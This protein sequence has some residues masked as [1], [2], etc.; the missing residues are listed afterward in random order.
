MIRLVADGRRPTACVNMTDKRESG[1]TTF[2]FHDKAIDM[3]SDPAQCSTKNTLARQ[4]YKSANH[5]AARQTMLSTS[6]TSTLCFGAAW[7]FG[8]G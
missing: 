5:T 8:D 4:H 6:A 1:S 2:K 7:N 3:P